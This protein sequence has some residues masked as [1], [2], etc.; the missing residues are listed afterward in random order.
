MA[1]LTLRLAL[2]QVVMNFDPVSVRD[3]GL[4]FFDYIGLT[5]LKGGLVSLKLAQNS[6]LG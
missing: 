5:I 3:D 2:A 4:K 1:N 6:Q